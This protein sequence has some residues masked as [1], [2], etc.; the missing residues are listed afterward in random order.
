MRRVLIVAGLLLLVAGF[1]VGPAA[2]VTP[3]SP[4]ASSPAASTEPP[5]VEGSVAPPPPPSPPSAPAVSDPDGQ[6]RQ[7]VV[8]VTPQSSSARV[9]TS[10]T[11]TITVE[12]GDSEVGGLAVKAVHRA[13]GPVAVPAASV[14]APT[15]DTPLEVEGKY[16]TFTVTHTSLNTGTDSIEATWSETNGPTAQGSAVLEWQADDSAGG[17]PTVEVDQPGPTSTVGEPLDLQIRVGSG[18]RCGKLTL[19]VNGVDPPAPLQRVDDT[20]YTARYSREQSGADHIEAVW[21]QRAAEPVSA[22]ADHAWIPV[23]RIAQ[24]SESSP[25]GA[26][27]GITVSVVGGGTDGALAITVTGDN[28]RTLT[29]TRVENAFTAEYT[30]TVMG[31]DTITAV[32]TQKGIPPATAVAVHS[33]GEA[34]PLDLVA[35]TVEADLGAPVTLTAH[36]NP[37]ELN[38]VRAQAGPLQVRFLV[39]GANPDE[40]VVDVVGNVATWTYTGL[41]TWAPTDAV[42]A[43]IVVRDGQP[44]ASNVVTVTWRTPTVTLTQDTGS[45]IVGQERVVTATVAGAVGG[46][47]VFAVEGVH[48]TAEKV[49]SGTHPTYTLRYRGTAAGQDLIVA[50]LTL[51]GGTFTSAALPVDWVV[52]KVT[53]DQATTVSQIDR[54]LVLTATLSPPQTR[55]AV[56][57]TA[58]GAGDP[59]TVRDDS[60]DGGFTATL[61]R[62][63]AGV[64]TITATWADAGAQVTSE[65][66][67]HDWRPEPQR[68]LLLAPGGTTSCAG[69]PFDLTMSARSGDTP[70]ANLPV[71]LAVS[72]S[73]AA[74]RAFTGTTDSAGVLPLTYTAEGAGA[75]TLTAT[76]TIDGTAVTSAPMTHT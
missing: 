7:P 60:A 50:R 31:R 6:A 13:P 44:P 19:L 48:A 76:T 75:D 30:G 32:W 37:V 17:T 29:P 54:D 57:F 20:H 22:V 10:V 62:P 46:S 8:R 15:T 42:Q 53:L 23:V 56:V 38:V 35:S 16:P 26:A 9:C 64:D 33:W 39:T 67:R 65:P 43:F 1:A 69:N 72:R 51:G 21:R 40:R 66:I 5:F 28:P 58:T 2:A 59:V 70:V 74:T 52:V 73:G 18:S 27:V 36:F 47:L 45:A 4:P 14:A 61:R 25:R 55:G 49:Q 68:A 41:G 11:F 3:P 71:Q 34:R 12:N 63:A 24:S